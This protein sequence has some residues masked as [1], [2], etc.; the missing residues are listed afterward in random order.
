MDDITALLL[1]I[2]AHDYGLWMNEGR[3][4]EKKNCTHVLTYELST[5]VYGRNAWLCGGWLATACT[6]SFSLCRFSSALSRRYR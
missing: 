6:F 4:E 5:L 2:I 3:K 1:T